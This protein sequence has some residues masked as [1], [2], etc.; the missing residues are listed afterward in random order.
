MQLSKD[1]INRK[2]N[3]F[4]KAMEEKKKK[5]IYYIIYIYKQ[6]DM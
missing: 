3:F 1:T 2:L 6:L 4:Y 5:N